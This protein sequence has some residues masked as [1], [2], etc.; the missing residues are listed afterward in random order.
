MGQ[1]FIYKL[2]LDSIAKTVPLPYNEYVQQY[3]DIYAKRKDM[4]GK[5]IGLSSYYFPIFDKALKD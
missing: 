4:F 5:M 1:N 2:R 3:I